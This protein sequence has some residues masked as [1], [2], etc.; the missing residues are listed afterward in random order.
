MCMKFAK[1]HHIPGLVLGT[2]LIIWG[3]IS[4][5]TLHLDWLNQLAAK[6]DVCGSY[7]VSFVDPIEKDCRCSVCLFAV[8]DAVH[9]PLFL[10]DQVAE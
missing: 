4:L 2:L 6:E 3:F 9:L 7:D 1:C 10:Q 8:K 5:S